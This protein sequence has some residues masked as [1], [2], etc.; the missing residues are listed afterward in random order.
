MKNP[1]DPIEKRTNDLAA[2]SALPQPPA[3]QLGI[4]QDTMIIDDELTGICEDAA[5]SCSQAWESL[6]DIADERWVAI[7]RA[8]HIWSLLLRLGHMNTR[9]C[10]FADFSFSRCHCVCFY[11]HGSYIITH[12]VSA[13]LL[14]GTLDDI[15]N[16]RRL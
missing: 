14:M 1:S 5:V 6:I 15:L 12:F 7:S 3:L 11:G 4:T 16:P 9:T 8:R 10:R 2:C 13:V